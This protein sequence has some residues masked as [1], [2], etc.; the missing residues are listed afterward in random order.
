[1]STKIDLNVMLTYDEGRILHVYPDT[2]KIPTCGIGHNLIANPCKKILGR[3]LALK[4]TISEEECDA[5]FEYDLEW[6]MQG[7]RTNIDQFDFLPEEY[8]VVL[9]N[10]SF[11]MGIPRLMGF[12]KMIAAMKSR[13]TKKA[14]AELK[15]SS[16][17]QQLPERVGRLV[18]VLEGKIPPEYI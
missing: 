6:V 8:R 16:L 11:N 9:I 3:T 1:M 12:K 7:L 5:L 13:Q 17:A 14:I 15:D 2:L 10:M 4:E 18:S